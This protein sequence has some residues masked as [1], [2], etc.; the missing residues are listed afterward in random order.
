MIFISLKTLILS[1][2]SFM[3]RDFLK[4]QM[5]EQKTFRLRYRKNVGTVS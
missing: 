4:F 5:C 1:I 3:I 2:F